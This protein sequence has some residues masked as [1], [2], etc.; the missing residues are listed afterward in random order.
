MWISIY[1][2]AFLCGTP[3]TSMEILGVLTVVAIVNYWL[4]IPTA[5]MA[6][7]FMILRSIY[8]KAGRSVKRIEAQSED[9]SFASF[10]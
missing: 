10:V 1:L 7:L 9:Y 3:Q 4:L 8:I 5:L 2:F 6:V